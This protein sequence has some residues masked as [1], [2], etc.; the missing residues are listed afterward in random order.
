LLSIMYNF[1]MD[2]KF[3]RT[4]IYI[5]SGIIVVFSLLMFV[6]YLGSLPGSAPDAKEEEEV[7]GRLPSVDGQVQR[8][9]DAAKAAGGARG[10]M[11]PASPQNLSTAA[12]NSAGAIRLVKD[13]NFGG[14][15]EAPKDMMALLSELS[16]GDKKKPSPIALKESDLINGKI[17]DLGGVPKKDPGLKVSSM[18]EMGRQPGQE[19]VTMYTAPVDYKV[20]KSS[21][22]WWAFANSHKCR[23]TAEAAPGFKPLSLASPDFSKETVLVLL[24]LSDLPNGI[25]KII[26]FEKSG[27]ALLVSYRVDPMAMAASGEGGHDF[28]SAVVVPKSSSIK[29]TQ[30]P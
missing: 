8:S 26:K 9:L 5:F 19:G 30:I 24:S 3:L 16:G 14:V 6:N 2:V 4:L 17:A 1:P 27:K 7:S 11:I 22:T 12:V 20:F 25:F 29:L 13:K 28:Y 15:A 23:S 18:P 21:D 10:S